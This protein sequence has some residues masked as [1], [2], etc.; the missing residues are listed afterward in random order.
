MTHKSWRLDHDPEQR[1]LG[2]NGRYGDSGRKAHRRKG[3]D[4]CGLCREAA[5]H[6]VRERRRGQPN[7]RPLS[8]CGTPAAARRH[9]LHGQKPCLPCYNAE[10]KYHKQNRAAHK[11][12]SLVKEPK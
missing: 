7:P 8:P 12:A 9:R 2:C 10:A 6:V 1:P 5:N 4:I 3:E 11:A